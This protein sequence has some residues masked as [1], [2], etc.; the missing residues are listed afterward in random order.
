[1][2]IRSFFVSNSSSSSFV[3]RCNDLTAWQM[4]QTLDLPNKGDESFNSDPW[5]IRIEG[6]NIKGSTSMDNFNNA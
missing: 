1:M 4:L 6:S 3:I 5:W 2:K